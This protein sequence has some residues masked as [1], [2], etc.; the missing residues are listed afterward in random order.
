MKRTPWTLPNGSA[1]TTTL[2][3][4]A[5]LALL[6]TACS[7][8]SSPSPVPSGSSGT[9]ASPS[10]APE[11][12][13]LVVAG[14][15]DLYSLDPARA[16]CD[17]CALIGNAIGDTLLNVDPDDFSKLVPRLA[18]DWSANA[19][20][21]EWTFNLRK[22]VKFH[23]GN[24]MTAQDVKL[25]FDRLKYIQGPP[26]F[27]FDGVDSIDAVGDYTVQFTLSAPDSGFP[28]K[29]TPPDMR[30]LDTTVLAQNGGVFDETAADKDT[31]EDF[32][33]QNSVSTGMYVF[34]SWTRE[35]EVVLEANDQYW[36]GKP[37]FSEIV[38]RDI[39]DVTT[40]RQLLDKGDA[41]VIMDV[42]PDTATQLGG[43]SG[44]SL[45]ENRGFDLIYLAMTNFSDL[46]KPMSDPLVHKAVQAA[47]DYQ[48]IT[49]DLG[50]GAERPAA[51]IPLGM[52]GIDRVSAVDQN[53]EQAKALMTQAGYAS[54]FTTE[55]PF[56]NETVYGISMSTLSAKIQSD[57]ADIGISVELL[58]MD[59]DAWVGQYRAKQSKMTLAIWA[60][61]WPDAS[62]YID[63]FGRPDSVVTKRIGL[64][65][66]QL[67]DLLSQALSQ[68]DPAKQDEIYAQ[69]AT[70]MRDDASL[71]PLVQPKRFYGYRNDL[72]GVRYVAA[73]L[74]DLTKISR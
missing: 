69:A 36:G 28:K 60:P 54:G 48:G 10:A 65:I 30:V 32:I 17:H 55:M 52:Q 1:R 62:E 67:G 31:A 40:E 70:I 71:I 44:V 8:T 9:E 23:T 20:A 43:M 47:L 19:D 25:S 24:P 21:T 59:Y 41:D 2:A 37:P 35:Q 39:K 15:S 46:D 34:K 33:N 29:L 58:P 4:T 63:A 16:W 51:M 72:H 61:D 68:S 7:G 45:A 6:V 66:P 22:D 38:I 42:T 18:T 56:W 11:R 5:A 57:L 13:R 53:V 64:Q 12:G 50:G 27:I 26:A 73:I 49:Q 74:L 14:A 3:I